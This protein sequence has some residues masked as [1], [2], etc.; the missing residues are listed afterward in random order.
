MATPMTPTL[1]VT[2]PEAQGTAFG[3]AIATT[4]GRPLHV[5]QSPLIAIEPVSASVGPADALIFTS[6]HGVAGAVRLGLPK[7]LPAWCVG[8]RTAE[9]ATAAGYKATTGPGNASGLV[10][11]L[12]TAQPAGRLAHLRGAHA[13]GDIAADLRQAGLDCTDTVVYAQEPLALSDR[14]AQ[15]LAGK[16]PVVVTLFSPR[17]GV[18][19]A[20]SGPYNAV[21]HAVVISQAV[22]DA[23]SD[24][25]PAEVIT[26]ATPDAAGMQRAVLAALAAVDGVS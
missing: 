24:L 26:A 8:P 7:G 22:K 13:R 20:E 5:I 19:F 17:T 23:I 14:A 18:I 10:A 12:I 1:I 2:R 21:V 3:Q 16:S 25:H 11:D 15:T 9:A 4:W 6:V